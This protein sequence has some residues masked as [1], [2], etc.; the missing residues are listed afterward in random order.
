MVY[1]KYHQ[2]VYIIWPNV[3]IYFSVFNAF[4]SPKMPEIKTLNL[5][6]T[7]I[8]KV[9]FIQQYAFFSLGEHGLNYYSTNQA[10]ELIFGGSL[11][12]NS[13]NKNAV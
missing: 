4:T 7:P 12:H 6:F 2:M 9:L 13:V 11:D 8:F 1:D 5:K 10:G 3:Q